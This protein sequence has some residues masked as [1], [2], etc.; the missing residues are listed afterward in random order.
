MGTP[1]RPVRRAPGNGHMDNPPDF[2]DEDEAKKVAPKASC[3]CSS[4]NIKGIVSSKS[5]PLRGGSSSPPQGRSS[6]TANSS[7]TREG[8]ELPKFSASRTQ[9][10]VFLY[11]GKEQRQNPI[12]NDS[13]QKCI[14]M[15]KEG[16]C[17][18]KARSAA[19]PY[20]EKH[21][22]EGLFLIVLAL[23]CVVF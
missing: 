16:P 20:C 14:A 18:A 6:N 4:H 11:E 5:G 10:G 17:M 1:L 2:E 23:M 22:K 21:L 3:G 13:S 9:E 12:T 15:T 19:V 8:G 7:I